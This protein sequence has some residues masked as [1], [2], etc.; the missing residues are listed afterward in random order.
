LREKGTKF[1]LDHMC[2]ES[3]NAMAAVGRFA[4]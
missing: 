4:M 2:Q 3:S 1:R